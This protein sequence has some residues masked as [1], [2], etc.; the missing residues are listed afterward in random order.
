MIDIRPE[1]SEDRMEKRSYKKISFFLIIILLVPTFSLLFIPRVSGN[2]QTYQNISVP[3]AY[4]MIKKNKNTEDLVIL[5]V[6]T[7]YESNSNHLYNALLIP[8]DEIASRITELE[9]YK[10]FKIIVYCKSG[11]RSII[12]S[13]LLIDYGFSKISNMI[14][15]IPAWVNEGY[16]IWSISHRV[17]VENPKKI[18]TE[19]IIPNPYL[20]SDNSCPNN[21]QEDCCPNNNQEDCCTHNNQEDSCPNPNNVDITSTIIEEFENYVITDIVISTDDTIDEFTSKT[22]YIWNS[23]ETS[24]KFTRTIHFTSIEVMSDDLN[25]KQFTLSYEVK[26]EQYNLTVITIL[27]PL[28]EETYKNSA[29]LIIFTSVEKTLNTFEFFEFNY[30]PISLSESYDIIGKAANKLKTIYSKSYVKTKEESFKQLGKN[31]KTIKMEVKKL[32]RF[33]KQNLL[34]YDLLIHENHA[35]IRDAF[36]PNGGGGGGGGGCDPVMLAICWLLIQGIELLGC[37]LGPYI[38]CLI[39]MYLLIPAAYRGIYGA[40]CAGL[41]AVFCFIPDRETREWYCGFAYGSCS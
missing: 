37:G 9:G 15:G 5:D 16:P 41:F 30:S 19:P 25:F 10:D 13:E 28:D 21:N 3:D 33:V 23:T 14:G 35:T 40:V 12:A 18:L 24:N 6:R 34:E 7:E 32:S 17:T 4:R 2:E 1:I 39:T 38:F 26:H 31:H 8:Y 27:T 20:F 22:T 11:G 29:T 36:V